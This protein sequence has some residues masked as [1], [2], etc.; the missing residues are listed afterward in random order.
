MRSLIPAIMDKFKCLTALSCE[1]L[2][3]E[4]TK[5]MKIAKKFK[6]ELKLAKLEIDELNLRLDESY[7]KNEFLRN[8]FSCQD[9]KMKSLE[10]KLA[11]SK[12]KLENLS[13]TKLLVDNKS[14]FISIPLKPKDDKVYIPHFKRNYKENAYFA[15]LDKGKNFDVDAEV[16]KLMPKPTSKL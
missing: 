6:E 5:S 7:K 1:N 15:R 14:V 12:S 9:E 13:S 4:D 10:Q 16:S 2:N 8:Q 3:K 11:E